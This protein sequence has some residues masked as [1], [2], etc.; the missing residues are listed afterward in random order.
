M[1]RQPLARRI[2]IA[3]T[4]MTV[5]VSGV[6]SLSIVG[7]VHM[8]EEHL[9]SEDM[10]HE[11]RNIIRND[12]QQGQPPR[13]DARTRLYA[14]GLPDRGIPQRYAG[15]REGFTEV[16]GDRAVYVYVRQ[17][18]GQRYVLEQE[19]EEFERRERALYDVVVMGFLLAVVA[20]CGLGWAMASAVVAPVRQLARQ[21]RDRGGC[22]ANSQPLARD[23]AD[24]EIGQL[25]RAFD[26][27]FRQLQQALERERLFTSDVSHELRTPLMIIASSCE[28][29]AQADL[30]TRQREQLERIERAAG[31]MRDL[32]QIFLELA[33]GT[34]GDADLATHT[35][36]AIARTQCEHWAPLMQ[37]RGIDF[38]CIETGRAAQRYN[39]TL[40]RTVMANLL[41]NALHYTEGGRVCLILEREAFRVEDTGAGISADQHER[42][43]ESFARGPRT[44]GEGLG[45]GL[46]LVKRI[47]QHQGWAITVHSRSPQG[48]CFKVVLTGDR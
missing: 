46:S 13:L 30:P 31:E 9:I 32:V 25:A 11:L 45:L 27:A 17:I 15:F 4:L 38:Q 33:R 10:D 37:A 47:C 23:Y 40:L 14:S 16:G 5:L 28:L 12:L 3:F 44:R 39:P 21:V 42:I 43:F 8:I 19:Q 7:I 1:A 18:D 35:L 34:S 22:A 41:R 24:D 6:F 29:L 48:T 36:A 2:V 26:S 20:A